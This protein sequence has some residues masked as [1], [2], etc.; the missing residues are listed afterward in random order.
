M[1]ETR[2]KKRAEVSGAGPKRRGRRV[3]E[4]RRPR[5]VP[6]SAAHL[7][8]ERFLVKGVPQGE[9]NKALPRP[10]L[11]ALWELS[12]SVVAGADSFSLAEAL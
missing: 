11:L 12:D 5:C 4:A 7:C 2:R 9:G 3:Q 10:A 8:H 6:G 1:E